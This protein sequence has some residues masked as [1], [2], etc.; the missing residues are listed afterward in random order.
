MTR[1]DLIDLLTGNFYDNFANTMSA[2]VIENDMVDELYLLAVSESAFLKPKKDKLLFR[3]AYTLEAIFFNHRD[4]FNPYINR[5]F[6]DFVSCT[7][8]SAK[9]HFSKIMS[10]LLSEYMPDNCD[11]IA[12]RC[13][14]WAVD[15]RL[16]VAA[17][18]GAVEVL[19]LLR[20]RVVWINDII[21][22]IVELM[23]LASC[24]SVECRVKRWRDV[25]AV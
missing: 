1:G 21:S 24:P 7:N 19:F 20:G 6:T 8:N 18:M 22:E 17:R 25:R 23:E 5:F 12:E 3:A 2:I 16:R 9:R 14:E 13:A 10:H 4:S 11:E 15:K